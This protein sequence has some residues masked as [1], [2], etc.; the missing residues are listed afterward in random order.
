MS[1]HVYEPC[2][3]RVCSVSFGRSQEGMRVFRMR[4]SCGEPASPAPDADG[5]R[6]AKVRAQPK[7]SERASNA[8][9]RGCR[10]MEVCP[11]VGDLTCLWPCTSSKHGVPLKACA[12]PV[13]ARAPVSGWHEMPRNA[14][15]AGL[16]V[17]AQV[18]TTQLPHASH[19]D[20]SEGHHQWKC[21]TTLM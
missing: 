7:R 5:A 20:A 3:T 9:A 6:N 4:L 2:W 21:G 1:A 13:G 15:S 10:S 12:A 11:H 17:C 14:G 18:R 8:L 19:V 16:Q